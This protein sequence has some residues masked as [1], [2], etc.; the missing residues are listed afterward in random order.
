MAVKTLLF[1][2]V[3]MTMGCQSRIDSISGNWITEEKYGFSH[4]NINDAEN[5]IR[6]AGDNSSS[7]VTKAKL[8]KIGNGYVILDSDNKMISKLEWSSNGEIN[9]GNKVY[10]RSDR[11]RR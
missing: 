10:H 9:I 2:M 8:E 3:I 5:H 1:L 7:I 4:V 6:F 11:T